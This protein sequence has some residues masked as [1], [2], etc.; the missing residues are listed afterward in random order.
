M[1]IMSRALS[2]ECVHRESLFLCFVVFTIIV[3]IFLYVLF[4]IQGLYIVVVCFFNSGLIISHEILLLG[5]GSF[6]GLVKKITCRT[7]VIPPR[8]A[9]PVGFSNLGV[10]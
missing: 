1:L 3:F 10:Q 2:A 5:V 8:D 7:L 4:L 6:G 9:A